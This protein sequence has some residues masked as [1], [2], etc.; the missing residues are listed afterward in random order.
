MTLTA[1]AP[2]GKTLILKADSLASEGGAWLVIESAG[3]ADR[4]VEIAEAPLTV[5]SGAD[6]AILIA[7]PHVSHRHAEFARTPGG[8]VLRDLG[9][10]NGT[11]VAN[12]AIKEAVLSSGA[13]IVIGKTRLRFEMGGE[14]GKLGRLVREPVR[15][16][17]LAGVPARF[18]DA[19]GTSAEM[20]RLFALLVRIAPT[21]LTV[22]LIGETGTGKDVLSRAIHDASP[23]REAPQ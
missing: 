3:Q 20:R 7:D 23:R 22:T 15:D 12:I 19:V 10:R 11:R 16:D 6:C 2:R 13:E 5:G 8:V 18:G 21:D 17:E 1:G 14:S 9:S 4:W